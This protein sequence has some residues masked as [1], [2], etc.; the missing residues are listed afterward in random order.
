MMSTLTE[1]RGRNMM[2]SF[3]VCV[4]VL[5]SA[6]ALSAQVATGRI[7]GRVTDSSGSVVPGA[8]VKGVN[9]QTNVE[10]STKTT[11]DGVFSVLNLIPGQYRLEVDMTGFKHFAQGPME[12]R[13]GDTLNIAV[14]LQV[15]AQSESVTVNAE[16]PLLESSSAATGQ[17]I[18]S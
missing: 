7:T 2:T 4:V 8:S 15:G 18:D 17:V 10:T 3:R 13:V 5:S 14:T 9:V 16:A 1:F 11:S 12:L 6:F